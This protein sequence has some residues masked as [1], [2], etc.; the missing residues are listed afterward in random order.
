MELLLACDVVVLS[1]QAK[2]GLPETKRALF[3]AGGGTFLGTRI[4]LGIALEMVLT[5]DTID[6]ER[7]YQIGLVNAVVHPAEVLAKALEYAETIAANGPLGLAAAKELV[8]LGVRN[9][10]EAK[11]RQ[12]ELVETVFAS[13]DAREGA[14]AFVEKRTPVW[15]GR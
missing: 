12:T 5:G 13:E 2:L 6:A 8:R 14:M 1:D 9:A 10:E 15:R 7:A 3:P 11:R 4:P